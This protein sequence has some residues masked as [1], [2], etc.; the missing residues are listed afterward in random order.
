MSIKQRS[1]SRAI[2]VLLVVLPAACTMKSEEAP[3]FTGPSEFGKS[4]N[5]TV[6]PDAIVQDGASQSVVMV[7][8]LGINSEPLVN[9][10]LRAEIRVDNVPTDFGSLSAR[11]IVTDGNGRA[12][13]VYTAPATVPGAAIDT[14]TIVQIG[15]TP[16]SGDAANAAT[17][18]ANLRLLPPGRVGPPSDLPLSFS[19]GTPSTGEVAAPLAFGVIPPEG[20][21]IVR[22]TWNFGDG[23]VVTTQVPSASHTYAQSGSFVV[24]VVAENSFGRTGTVS[25]TI[26]IAQSQ[27]PTVDFAVSPS[28]PAPNQTVRFNASRSEPAPGRSIVSYAWDFGN[29]TTGSGVSAQAVYSQIGT[30]QVTL[31]VTDDLGRRGVAVK[32]VAVKVPTTIR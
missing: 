29:G 23:A 7:T 6:T 28:D 8:A 13:L 18:F 32:S 22:Y 26:A 1:F 31:T 21:T 20:Q 24:T 27:A 17:R 14:Q 9:I 15:V 25:R 2:A 19:T 11:N 12:T 5:V 30:Y 10:P 16:V 3:S 4:I